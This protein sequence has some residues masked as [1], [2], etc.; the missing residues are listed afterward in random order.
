MKNIT[1][2]LI[3]AL[4]VSVISTPL[5][6]DPT[7]FVH[8]FEWKWQDVATE[9]E[10]YLGPKGYAAVQ[11]SPPNE[12]IQGSQ[13]WTRYQPVSYQLQSRGGSRAEFID[14]VERC[15]NSGVEI[16][17][18]A[19]INHMGAGS[20]TGTAG[21]TYGNRQFPIYGPQDFHSSCTINSSD[22]GSD[23]WRVQNCELVG[24]PDLNTSSSYVQDTIA[25]YLNDLQNIGVSGF[26]F[27]ASKHMSVPDIQGI[28]SKVNGT[29]LV[30]MEV[31]DQGGEAVTAAE[32]TG[33]GLVT[34][35]KYST[36]LGNTFR[37]GSL[38]WLSNFGEAW[39]FMPSS[40]AV[41][42]V[43]NHD[44]QRGHGGAGN[45]ITFE[46]GRL[47]DLA[48]V[49]MLAYPYG[50][51]KVMSSYDYHGDTDAGGP[52]VAVHNN[53]TLE[54]FDT[55][56]KCEHRWSY[57]AG[58]VDFRNNTTATWTT[59]N[60]WDNG[61]NQIAFGR[62]ESGHVAINKE[63]YNMTASIQ[64]N[65]EPG[66]YCNVLKGELSS[67]GASCS[68]ETVTVNQNGTI[69]LDIAPWD[70]IAIH[71]NAKIIPV[72]CTPN[73]DNNDDWQRTV[74]FIQAQ[75][76]SGQDMFIRG[77]IDHDYANNQ[78]G[79]NCDTT[80]FDCAMPIRHLNLI[81]A[82]TSPW[83]AN[84]NYLDWYGV[85]ASQSSSAEGTAMDWTT[86]IWPTSWGT[87]KTVATDGYGTEPLN[88]WGQHYWMLDVEMDCSKAVNGWFELKAFV[89][90]GQGWES[91]IAQVNAPYSSNNHFAQCGK[92][93]KFN[94][95]NSSVEIR[96]F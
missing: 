65:M 35:F 57:I 48:N 6:A 70:A 46:D 32:Y 69:N 36:Q 19:V 30:F 96:D 1:L 4:S 26:R 13:W 89:K 39:G 42:F 80:N 41:V 76:Q 60:W 25:G 34:E 5:H 44:N 33:T 75:T 86:D 88:I 83:K 43:D 79:R 45:V 77:G 21:S 8:L 23:R 47:Y 38:A 74:I 2:N 87:E 27:D 72:G 61:N 14:M 18:D 54:C 73:C 50:Y 92:I 90:N 29:P 64:T 28:L 53:G 81:N 67:D 85:E 94:F 15:N 95:N 66:T 24:L 11:V 9:C 91:N 82:T 93:N 84:D 31:I 56:W 71:H 52:G 16:Y 3:A 22:Y 12:H 78:L 62:G 58:A 68:G 20:G 63:D 10:Q 37:N 49:F 51:P 55:N 17:V 59:T 40:S 7:T